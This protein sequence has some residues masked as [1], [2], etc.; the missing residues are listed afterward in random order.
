MFP[1]LFFKIH[2]LAHFFNFNDIEAFNCDEILFID[3]FF[4]V[5]SSMI[6]IE[7][8]MVK[9]YRYSNETTLVIDNL[10]LPFTYFYD[11][12]KFTH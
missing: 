6:T 9:L 7:M 3:L 4:N 11:F 5:K 8:I 12:K 2:L 10:I 1:R